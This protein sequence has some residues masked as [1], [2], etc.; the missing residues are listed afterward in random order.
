M[1]K[2]TNSRAYFSKFVEN[3]SSLFLEKLNEYSS[4]SYGDYRNR[5]EIIQYARNITHI[6]REK[7]ADL[8]IGAHF[9]SPDILIQ[10]VKN[11]L[12][13]AKRQQKAILKALSCYPQGEAPSPLYEFYNMHDEVINACKYF[14]KL[15]KEDMAGN[16]EWLNDIER[17]SL[18]QLFKLILK[19][20]LSAFAALLGFLVSIFFLGGGYQKMWDNNSVP[21]YTKDSSAVF[22]P[23]K[24]SLTTSV[25]TVPKQA[26][27]INQNEYVVGHNEATSLWNGAVLLKQADA[28]KDQIEFT[29]IVGWNKEPMKEKGHY[30]GSPCTAKTGDQI[31]IMTLNG[32]IWRINV[33]KIEFSGITI[34]LFPYSKP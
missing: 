5:G 22:V 14:L 3:H 34:E 16:P 20:K 2:L 7:F 27:F 32:E 1:N 19:L 31:Y 33:I 11:F 18:G 30:S 17:I 4:G 25:D 9:E 13:Q 12:K 26:I 24:D 10:A 28:Y 29:G 6:I 15:S 8:E 23:T 21:G